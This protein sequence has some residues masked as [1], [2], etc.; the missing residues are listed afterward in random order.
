M[1][2][3]EYLPFERGL[4]DGL[5]IYWRRL[6]TF[7]LVMGV[8]GVVLSAG[9]F[10]L[11]GNRVHT[12]IGIVTMLTLPMVIWFAYR[13]A[14]TFRE[15]VHLRRQNSELLEEL[16]RRREAAEEANVAKSRFLAVA[17]HDLRQP[18]HALGLF[19]QALQES[20][21]AA[22]ERHI[23]GN[24]LRSVDA[25]EEL[26]DALLD[27]SRL[28][29]G[30]VRPRIATIPLAPLMERVRAEYDSAAREKGLKLRVVRN[31]LFVRSDAVLIERIMRNLLANAVRYTDRGRVILGA[32]RTADSVRIEVWDS[33]RGIPQDKHREIFQ[34]FHQLDNPARGLGLGLAIVKR[35]VKLLD[36]PLELRSQLGRGSVFAM[37]VPRGRREDFI[38]GEADGQIVVDRDV[39]NSLILVVDD[40]P[41]VR[42]SILAMLGQW[43]GEVVAAES[44][45]EMLRKLVSIQRVPDLIVANY[46]LRQESGIDVIARLREKFNAQVPALLITGETGVEQLREAAKSGLLVLRK[47]LVPSRL[48]ALIATLRREQTRAA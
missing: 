32:R 38:S 45:A 29:A 40:E 24:I 6:N 46:R 33:G 21:I 36:H 15:S 1:T 12:S 7:L 42:D 5:L 2:P 20:S 11:D 27:I 28:D 37:T 22:Q 47:P 13:V 25:M 30:I 31:S 34:E 35:L 19:V 17:S 4:E 8:S 14:C 10:L 48:R 41:D 23:V 44:C 16:R 39:A 18:L 26:F 9:H 3:A 43:R